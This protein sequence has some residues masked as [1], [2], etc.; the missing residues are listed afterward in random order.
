MKTIFARITF[1]VA[2]AAVCGYALITLRGESGLKALAEKQ[3][4]IKELEER[5]AALAKEIE[6]K[7]EHIRRLTENP[8][9]QELEIRDR[10]KLVRPDEKVY[11]IGG[12]EAPARK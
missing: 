6:R 7:R 4:K 11:I 9:E 12:K 3:A 10:L 2:F 5:N 8:A 1:A